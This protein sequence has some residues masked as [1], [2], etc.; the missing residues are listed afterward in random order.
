[1]ESCI[2]PDM[3]IP[4][5]E[6]GGKI[7]EKISKHIGGSFGRIRQPILTRFRPPA[8]VALAWCGGRGFSVLGLRPWNLQKRFWSVLWEPCGA[9][10][11]DTL[12]MSGPARACAL[13]RMHVDMRARARLHVSM[14]EMF[15]PSS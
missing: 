4:E 15:V 6:E 2:G 5:V 12:V 1:M 9:S 10:D 13:V 11:R 7:K 14:Q 3:E 8:G